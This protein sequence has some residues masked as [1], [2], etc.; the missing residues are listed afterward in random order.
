MPADRNGPVGVARG[1]GGGGRREPTGKYDAELR[2]L[3][4]TGLGDVQIDQVLALVLDHVRSSA[5]QAFAADRAASAAEE[6]HAEW[7]S[8]AGP[9]LAT[10]ITP[11]RYPVASRVGQA[12]GREFDAPSDPRRAFTF[13][14]RT[15]LDGV[16]QLT[17]DQ[18]G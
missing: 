18:A 9:L 15:L 14:L 8:R 2:A 7:W 10:L 1:A 12:A 17:G 4:G 16:E 11:E 13:G 6:S 5:R 3:E